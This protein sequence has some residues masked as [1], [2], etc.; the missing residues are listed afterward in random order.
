MSD[1]GQPTKSVAAE[2]R[3][4]M[5]GRMAA[6]GMPAEKSEDFG[7]AVRRLVRRMRPDWF[8][9]IAVLVLAVVSVTLLVFGPKILGHATD[10]IVAGI[11][12]PSGIDFNELHRV[13][14]GV[15][16]LYVAGAS[17]AYLQNWMLAG[18]VQRTMFRLR[19][20]VEDKLNRLPLR[21]V[22]GQPRGD[23]LSR[24]TNDIDNVA[25]SLQQ[26]LSQL[27][28]STLTIVGVVIMMIT[29][30]PLL[31]LVALITIPLSLFTLRFIASRSKKRFVAQW[32]HTGSLNAQVEEAFTGLALVKVFGRQRD[33][34]KRFADKNEELYE[35]SFG[36][37]FISGIIQP[38]MMFLGNLNFVAVAVI[39]GL[40][41]SS[42]ALT[43]GDVQ[44]FIQYSRQFTQPITQVAS[45]ANVL[46]S[47]IAS[48]ERVFQLLDAEEEHPDDELRLFDESPRGRVEFDHVSFSY[49]PKNPLIQDLSL[50]AEPGET[51][52]IVG[53]T[54]AGKTTLVNLIMRFYEIDDG[55]IRLD[56]MDT[57]KMRRRDLRANVGMVLQDTWLFGATIRENIAFGNLDATEEQIME[58]A[59]GHVCRPLRALAARR[60]RHGD[61]RRGRHRQRGREAVAH[62]RPCLP[63]RSDH[64]HPRRGHQLGRHPYRGPDPAR[65]GGAAVEPHQLRHRPPSVDDPRRRHHPRHGGRADRRA[66]RPHRAAGPGWRLLHAVQRAVRRRGH[67]SGVIHRNSPCN[68][69]AR[70]T[71]LQGRCRGLVGHRGSVGQRCLG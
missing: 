21:Y 6:A 60:L 46:Q 23:L 58:A 2:A 24:V 69:V 14:L 43:I 56:G 1:T 13:L 32:T 38:A 66:G 50:V 29:I 49:D 70:A 34:E 17:L 19:S 42:G 22:D 45:M 4:G 44:A 33:V 61:R 3:S 37:Q 5:T 59:E 25:Q 26:S 11:Q 63:G 27:L 16:V 67:R 55:T 30:S 28:T 71:E 18:V 7:N 39:G 54:G 31:S 8:Q 53:P 48:A 10:V 36:A 20:D 41:V 52:A 51:V 64:P 9:I 68:S 65:H 15:L 35:A 62:D 40:R 57:A 12:S 47:G